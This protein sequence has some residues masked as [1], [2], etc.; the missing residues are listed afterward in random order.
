MDE[1]VLVR[2]R[3]KHNGDI[4]RESSG[5]EPAIGSSQSRRESRPL[6]EQWGHIC[7]ERQQLR[8]GHLPT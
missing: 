6:Q 7:T 8:V 3:P 5:Y 2:D 1:C 4:K